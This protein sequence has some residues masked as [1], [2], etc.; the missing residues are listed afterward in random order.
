MKL[1]AQVKRYCPFCKKHTQQKVSQRKTGSKRG[2][3]KHGSLI[4]AKM[5]GLARGYGNLGKYGS[6]PAVSSF[7]RTTKSSKKIALLYTCQECKKGYTG[8]FT[9]RVKKF[10]IK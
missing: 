9:G 7:K 2:S 4:R 10:E 1:K 3:L 5:R 8:Q 6:K